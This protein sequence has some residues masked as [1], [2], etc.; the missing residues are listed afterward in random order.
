ML[1]KQKFG[2]Y[3]VTGRAGQRLH[4]P[5]QQFPRIQYPQL[6]GC[7]RI[8]Q[9]ARKPERKSHFDHPEYNVV[10]IS[11]IDRHFLFPKITQRF[12]HQQTNNDDH[13]YR[14]A[15]QTESGMVHLDK[16]EI[17]AAGGWRLTAIIDELATNFKKYLY[18]VDEEKHQHDQQQYRVAAVEKER[19]RVT[20]FD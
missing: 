14:L 15:E 19:V 12:G 13:H 3:L 9:T 7:H 10:P 20:V 1:N 8:P 6:F 18:A 11:W 5:L 2:S 17:L 4:L 16:V